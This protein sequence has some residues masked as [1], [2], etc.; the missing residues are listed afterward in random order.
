VVDR[1]QLQRG[2]G[3]IGA[4]DR[5]DQRHGS[6]PRCPVDGQPPPLQELVGQCRKCRDPL[7]AGRTEVLEV[8]GDQLFGDNDAM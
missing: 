2:G 1:L 5:E 8:R 3:A 7:P 6:E 4:S